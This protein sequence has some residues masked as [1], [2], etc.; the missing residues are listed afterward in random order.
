MFVN[1]LSK[2]QIFRPN[3]WFLLTQDLEVIHFKWCI[4]VN[5]R[6]Q[7]DALNMVRFNRGEPGQASGM[8][9]T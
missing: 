5:S 4:F 1:N 3:K 7:S 2:R 8:L 6:E 9:M